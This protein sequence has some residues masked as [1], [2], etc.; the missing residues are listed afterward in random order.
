M[1]AIEEDLSVRVEKRNKLIFAWQELTHF[2][3]ENM[4]I[5]YS[6]QMR[7]NERNMSQKR[8]EEAKKSIDQS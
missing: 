4:K 3:V 7:L 8:R 2:V 1:G 6:E 5:G